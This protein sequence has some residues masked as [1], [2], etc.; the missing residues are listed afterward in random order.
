MK[1]TIECEMEEYQAKD[2]MSLLKYMECCGNI[3]HTSNIVVFIDGD[4]AFRP[5]FKTT[6]TP[7]RQLACAEKSNQWFKELKDTKA[8]YDLRIEDTVF[9]D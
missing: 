9:L 2:L 7:S 1:F 5:K 4:G 3:G 6:V 8:G